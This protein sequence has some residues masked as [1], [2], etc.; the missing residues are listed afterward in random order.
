[1]T[2]SDV[3]KATGKQKGRIPPG[4]VG[5]LPPSIICVGRNLSTLKI[6][7]YLLSNQSTVSIKKAS[8]M[9]KSDG[10]CFPKVCLLSHIK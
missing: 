8:N 4:N 6:V 5:E 7:F 9:A 2:V 1:M 3:L 10:I